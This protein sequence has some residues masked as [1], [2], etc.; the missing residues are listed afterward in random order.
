V[1]TRP[2]SNP[3]ALSA[4]SFRLVYTAVAGASLLNYL[5]AALFLSG[6]RYVTVFE[7]DQLHALALHSLEGF[8][9][10]FSLALVFFGIHLLLLGVLLFRSSYFPKVLGVLI[11][12]AG[13]AYLTD[14]LS[15]FLSPTFHAAV[16]PFLAVPASFELVLALW[17]LVKGVRGGPTPIES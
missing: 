12:L 16:A 8:K 6:A 17:L 10:G 7:T 5:G 13:L 1:L 15:L 4:A 14:S 3:L 11:A 2:V 9:Q